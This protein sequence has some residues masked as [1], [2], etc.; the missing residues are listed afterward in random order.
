MNDEEL[1]Q[2]MAMLD[3]YRNQLESAGSQIQLLQMSLDEAGRAKDTLEAFHA[4]K[5]GDELL[6]PVGASSFVRARV[7]DAD[8]AIIGVGNKLSV[9]RK[10]EDAVTYLASNISELKDALTKSK[11]SIAELEN[12]ARQLS[13]AVQKAYQERQ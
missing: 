5:E 10:M 12:R 13:A 2:A 7:A 4:S 1:R 11:E 3:V 8:V 6:V 9:E